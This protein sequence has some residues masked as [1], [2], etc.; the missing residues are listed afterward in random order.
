[1]TVLDEV[2]FGI[3]GTP[4]LYELE[5]MTG[6]TILMKDMPPC[7][8]GIIKDKTCLHAGRIVMRT[9]SPDKFEVMDMTLARPGECWTGEPDYKVILLEADTILEVITRIDP[10]R[11]E[12]ESVEPDRTRR[13]NK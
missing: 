8:W 10:N 11:Y 7:S 12:V 1:M 13:R 4:N 5:R 3:T 2:S 6:K 9:A